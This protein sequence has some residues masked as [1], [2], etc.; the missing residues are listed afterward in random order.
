MECDC[1]IMEEHINCLTTGVPFR[2]VRRLASAGRERSAEP[3]AARQTANRECAPAGGRGKEVM[4]TSQREGAA[5]AARSRR[6][7]VCSAEPPRPVQL[8]RADGR[9]DKSALARALRASVVDDTG[10]PP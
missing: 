1:L 4:P 10:S 6:K 8:G 2:R 5:G 3:D 7:S 9:F